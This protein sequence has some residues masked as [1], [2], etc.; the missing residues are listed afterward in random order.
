V[1]VPDYAHPFRFY[2]EV[3]LIQKL[4]KVGQVSGAATV[5]IGAENCGNVKV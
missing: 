5:H 3:I 2:Q 1:T 4:K